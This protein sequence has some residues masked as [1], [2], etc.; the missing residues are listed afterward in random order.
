MGIYDEHRHL[1]DQPMGS[2]LFEVG[3]ILGS[4]GNVK[5]KKLRFGGVLFARAEAIS[6]DERNHLHLSLQGVNLMPTEGG[7][8]GRTNPFF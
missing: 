4:R 8:F 7:L 6:V 3:D 5:A 1:G 2:A